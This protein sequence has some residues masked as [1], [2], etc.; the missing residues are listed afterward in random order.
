MSAVLQNNNLNFLN[1]SSQ[2]LCQLSATA[3]VL[4]LS[5]NSGLGVEIKGLK[6]P[7][8][9]TSAVTK[10]YVDSLSAGLQWKTSVRATTTSAQTLATDFANGQTIDG[11]LL[12]TNDRILIKN[13]ANGVENGIYIVQASGAPTRSADMAN[14]SEAKGSAVFCEEG[15]ANADHGFVVSSGSTVGTD[16]L[17][18][19][20]FTSL[21]Q[22]DAGQGLSKAGSQLDV[23]VDDS[24]IEISADTLQVKASGIQN[25]HL[26]NPS[27]TVSAGA[28]LSSTLETIP[29]GS[30][31][32]LSVNV[33]DSTIEIDS[34][35]LRVKADGINGSHIDWGTGANQVN[36]ED[37]PLTTHSWIHI[38][39]PTEVQDCLEKL[40]AE[41][42]NIVGG[43]NA[44]SMAN[45]VATRGGQG[46]VNVA[47]DDSTIEVSGLV[48]SDF[49]QLK[50]GGIVDAK[51]ANGTISNSKLVNDNIDVK[52]STGLTTS[53][54]NIAL[55]GEATLGIDWAEVVRTSSNQSIAGVKTFSDTTAS[56][57]SSTGA[58]ILSAGGLGCAGAGYFNGNLTA[59]SH[60]STSD[61]RLKGD[62][63]SAQ[64]D[65][66]KLQQINIVDF[67]WL[68]QRQRDAHEHCGVIAQQLKNIYPQYVRQ[69]GR[70]YYSVDYNSLFSLALLHIQDLH[71]K[72]ERLIAEC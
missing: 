55:G 10:N 44:I 4:T 39:A 15:T 35:S 51:I 42:N 31:G 43:G 27:L 3:D 18:Y 57:S 61:A 1:G 59:S 70:G 41:I 54:Q 68:D 2:S 47:V 23:N 22:V 64:L 72:Y 14:A 33:D 46:L 67:K 29:L 5:S 25:S 63:K 56:T 26:V 32:S 69:D 50:N 34:N 36:A 62:I 21:G 30:S 60:I 65:Y 48:G 13:Q 37:I 7:T 66:N 12:A 45:G 40:D 20:Q 11:V 9:S 17:V 52:I 24:T 8:Q 6:D 16:I 28:A 38:T 19:T 53:A 71:Q 49:L 58:V